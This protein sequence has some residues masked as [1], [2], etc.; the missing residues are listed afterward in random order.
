[1]AFFECD[2]EEKRN[3]FLRVLLV[4]EKLEHVLKEGPADQALF[5][6]DI[7]PPAIRNKY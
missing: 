1:M 2:S 6:F 5:V 3:D 4:Y 7:K